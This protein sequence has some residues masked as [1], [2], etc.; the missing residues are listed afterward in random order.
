MK[1]DFHI[2]EKASMQKSLYF[3]CQLIE[4]AYTDQRQVYIHTNSREEAERLDALLWTYRDDSFIPHHLYSHT[5]DC[6]PPIQIGF[7]D[8]SVEKAVDSQ[9]VLVN[10]SR[11]IPP[12]YKQFKH[13]IEIVFS[14]SDMQQL[15]RERYR[16][17]RDQGYEINTNKL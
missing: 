1:I 9:D 15:A 7:G 4:K 2:L 10:L 8:S 14:D 11:E 6:P 12:F 16:Q 17:Y 5:D 13:I 3:A